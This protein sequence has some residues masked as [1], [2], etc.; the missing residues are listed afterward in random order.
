MT[1]L[2][3]TI[4]DEAPNLEFN[5]SGDDYEFLGKQI[6]GL[7]DES[8]ELQK[9]IAC[10]IVSFNARIENISDVQERAFLRMAQ[11]DSGEILENL[12]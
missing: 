2:Y 10:A 3:M 12:L 8:Q 11:E 4:D 9:V 1:E 6:A 7:M 5:L